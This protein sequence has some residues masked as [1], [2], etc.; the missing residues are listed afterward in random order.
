M[1]WLLAA[2]KGRAAG[3]DS[4]AVIEPPGKQ[5]EPPEG[6]DSPAG[7]E[8]IEPPEGDDSPAGQEAIEPPEGDD[9]P[10]DQVEESG[11]LHPPKNQEV[12]KK[13]YKGELDR[14]RSKGGKE[15]TDLW[16]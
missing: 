5:I 1:Q 14:R 13:G 10:E 4:P 16:K 9:S 8:A 2:L 15:T 6:D 7:Q 12:N 3:D 11:K